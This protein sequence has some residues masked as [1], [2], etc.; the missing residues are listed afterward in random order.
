M[1]IDA[2]PHTIEL[3]VTEIIPSEL[4]S[5]GDLRIEAKASVNG[6]VGWGYCWVEADTFKSFATSVQQLYVF[7]RH[8]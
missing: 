2:H 4:P 5:G 1:R 7:R 8:R 6:F 3:N